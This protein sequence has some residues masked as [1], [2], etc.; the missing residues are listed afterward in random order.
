MP[1]GPRCRYA[2]RGVF[3]P[4]FAGT[5]PEMRAVCDRYIRSFDELLQ[6][7]GGRRPARPGPFLFQKLPMGM[8]PSSFPFSMPSMRT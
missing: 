1:R 7:G 4:F 5:E 3:D 2:R 8:E 6:K